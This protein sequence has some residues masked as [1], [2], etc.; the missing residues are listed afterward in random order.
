MTDM[1]IAASSL[2]GFLNSCSTC[3]TPSAQTVNHCVLLLKSLFSALNIALENLSQGKTGTLSARAADYINRNYYRHNLSVG[4]VAAHLGV[5]PNYLVMRFNRETGATIR[6]YLIQTRM[7]HARLLLQS[8]CYMV[9][10]AARLTGWNSAYYFS[11]SF[12]KH[13]GIP[14][15]A[16]QTGTKTPSG[17]DNR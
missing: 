2:A 4:D 15:S 9:K 12:H 13:F 5:T 7:E 17:Y 11:N 16:I 6:Q 3:E 8:G 14:P 10:D 1:G